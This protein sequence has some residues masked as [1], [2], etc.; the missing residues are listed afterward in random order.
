MMMTTKCDGYRSDCYRN[1]DSLDSG[2]STDTST[3]HRPPV[4]WSG[5][6]ADRS[7]LTHIRRTDQQLPTPASVPATSTLPYHRHLSDSETDYMAA[8]R[9]Q[10]GW[11]GQRSCG[12]QAPVC[13]AGE[14][15]VQDWTARNLASYPGPADYYTLG[16]RRHRQLY[17]GV[18]PAI[19]TGVVA[20]NPITA[21]V[22]RFAACFI[23]CSII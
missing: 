3:L 20:D 21:N 6:P 14:C 10:F 22:N 9:Q 4:P 1:E 12:Q 2:L 13:A 19:N 16:A 7:K 15:R 5:N 18:A 17:N 23:D 8:E 11:S